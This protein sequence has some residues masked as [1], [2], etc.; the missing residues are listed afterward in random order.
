MSQALD[1]APAGVLQA[2][3]LFAALPADDAAALAG[4]MHPLPLA[5]GDVLFSS[6][7]APAALYVVASGALEV[8]ERGAVGETRVRTLGPGEA[9]DEMQALAG[10]AGALLVRASAPA[11]LMRVDDAARDALADR[12]PAV[13]AALA[14]MHRQQLFCRLHAVFGAMDAA[15]LDEL[16]QMAEWRHLRRGELL[17]E[18]ADSG[19]ALYLVISGR[20]RT[21]RIETDGTARVLGEA[22]RGE[23]AGEL[24][25]F[26]CEPRG[27]RVEA[28][29]DAVLVGFTRDEFD[30]L[31]ARRPA[32]IRQ[33]TR[34]VLDRVGGA[35]TPAPGR[36]IN[37]AVVP[38]GPGAPLDAFCARLASALGAHGR[39]LHLTAAGVDARMAERDIA[40]A[41]DD[42]AET[43]R[44]LAWLE[45]R[46][47]DHRFVLYQADESASAWT[48]RCMR[49]ADRVLLLA[50]AGDDP[51]PGA[52]E[53]AVQALEDRA[54]DA[55]EALVLV[56]PDGS[57]LPS[58]TA[59]WL[60]PRAVREHHHV[61]WDGEADF[62][63][64]ARG[65]AGRAVGVV[66]GGG[67]ARGMAHIGVL[68]A[69]TE[70]GVPIDFIGG[71]SIGAGVAAQYAYGVPADGLLELNRRI[72]LEWQP[73]KALTI[74]LVSLVDNRLAGVCG[75]RVYGDA[76]IEDL[77]TPYFCVTSNL[78]TAEMV[79]HR[80]GL[81]RK[82]VLASASIPVF[83]PPVLE[84][85]HLL[86]DGA[87]LN[88]LP[89]D[90]MRQTGCGVVIAS[91][92]SVDDD[93]LFTAERV[94]TSWEVLR[95]RFRRGAPPVKFPGLMDVAMR[96]A[97][98]HSTWREAAAVRE[99]DICL[100]PPVD[101]FGLME[102]ERMADVAQAGYVYAR[103]AVADWAERPR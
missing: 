60:R 61:R 34:L 29:R 98:L 36:V 94:P 14:R 30:R 51:A 57:K 83:A 89:T 17:W 2:S 79:I 41:W 84:G 71:T 92:V 54:T 100:R 23:I 55:Y 33:V 67:G 85:S 28:V 63:R 56:H 3:P 58:G 47:T 59:A 49:Q 96:A 4:A 32:I 8:V 75:E 82:Y 97:L 101:A 62:A 64:L 46:E 69:L 50:R 1:L 53:R 99:A 16:E 52:V 73:Q 103:Q 48:R 9:L 37:V 72:Y 40:Q 68:R 7:D 76:H 13:A 35:R 39:T 11:T 10:N 42:G 70:A 38:V 21:V 20:L 25:F 19:D 65:M 44:L 102:F 22:G 43:E 77:W 95:G 90:V 86:V 45:A 91:E 88:N 18:Q 24:A 87:L 12:A 5:I 31:V 15:L 74:P 80:T 81:L 93:A 78:S 26:G 66:L 6:D 27:E